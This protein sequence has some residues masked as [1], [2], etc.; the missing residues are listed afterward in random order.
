MRSEGEAPEGRES[1]MV[2]VSVRQAQIP[3]RAVT[4]SSAS[5]WLAGLSV[6]QVLLSWCVGTRQ[7]AWVWLGAKGACA[8]SA[9]MA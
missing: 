4:G 5:Q 9:A 1:G 3:A 7:V 6:L 2:I 8:E